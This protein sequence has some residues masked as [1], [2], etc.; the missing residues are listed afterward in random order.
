MKN[1]IKYILI[2]SSLFII[3]IILNFYKSKKSVFDDIMIF[4][5]WNNHKTEYEISSED[6]VEI[7]VFM[8]SKNNIY[9]KVAPGTNGEFVIKFKRPPNSNYKIQIK[10]KTTKPKNIIFIVGNQKYPSLESMEQLINEMF[11]NTEQITIKWEWKYFIND[12]QDIQDTKDGEQAQ[13]Y[14]FEVETI[15]E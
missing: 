13:N 9:K 2:L 1:I 12:I 6:T 4:S 11:I 5:L 7:D 10:E 14:I 15:I 3:F 8:T